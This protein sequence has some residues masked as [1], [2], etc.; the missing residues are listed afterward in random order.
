MAHIHTHTHHR[1]SD[2]YQC[3]IIDMTNY[4]A[5]SVRPAGA[6]GSYELNSFPD[7]SHFPQTPQELQ[8]AMR[9]FSG[10]SVSL[11]CRQTLKAVQTNKSDQED[12]DP[13][14]GPETRTCFDSPARPPERQGGG[15]CL[16]KGEAEVLHAH[17]YHV[18]N[19]FR[20]LDTRALLL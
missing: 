3:V 2:C 14:E 10:S 19:Q 1:H 4:Y 20:C 16:T 8:I 11:A 12:R 6:E 17:V 18:T 15:G 13:R 5:G 7:P 9:F